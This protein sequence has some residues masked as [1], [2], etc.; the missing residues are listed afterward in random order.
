MSTDDNYWNF[1]IK[2]SYKKFKEGGNKHADRTTDTGRICITCRQSRFRFIG[3]METRRINSLAVGGV[4][5]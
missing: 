2:T 1:V 3:K 5:P 4:P